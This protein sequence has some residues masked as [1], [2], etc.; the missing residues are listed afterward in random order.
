MKPKKNRSS[1]A[2][3]FTAKVAVLRTRFRQCQKEIA[4]L[5]WLS[6]GSITEN[7]PGTWRWTRKLKAKTVT[8]ALSAAQAEAFTHAIA[9]HRCLERLIREMRALSQTYLLETIPGPLRRKSK[10]SVQTPA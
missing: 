3:N 4:D 9:N 7:H 2:D 6:E 8:V 10:K 5:D 1:G